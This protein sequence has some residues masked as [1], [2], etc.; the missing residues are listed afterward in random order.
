MVSLV[1]EHFRRPSA[2]LKASNGVIIEEHCSILITNIGSSYIA[3]ESRRDAM[4]ASATVVPPA[5]IEWVSKAQD[6]DA[7]GWALLPR[8]ITR[9]QC[10]QLSALYA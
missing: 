8:L 5:S 2:H 3:R 9:D 6:L 1:G 4:S 7:R 10:R